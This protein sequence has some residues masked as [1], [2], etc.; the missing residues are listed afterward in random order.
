MTNE[1][2]SL[3]TKHALAQA[4]KNEMEHKKLSKITITELCEICQINRKTFYYHFEDIYALLK[5]TLEQEA[6]EVVKNIDLVV[7]TEE[8]LR[9]V[10]AYADENKHII[11]CALDSMGSEEL[12]RF[13]YNDLFSVIYG[14]IEEGE[15]DLK[16]T[17]DPQF[18]KFLAA[19][20]TEASAG[21]LI[22]WV[23]TRMTQDK[24]TIIQSLLS[25]YKVSIPAILLENKLSK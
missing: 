5:W 23:K 2:L 21:L 16:I 9:F 19:F 10:M 4:L 15:Y 8:A 13:F 14:A 18:K 24:E 7:N 22:E 11:H 20:Y 1:E 6:V 12:K 25:I 17:V 3:K